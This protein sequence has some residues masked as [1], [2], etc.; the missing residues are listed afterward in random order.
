MLRTFL[1]DIF[2]TDYV[3]FQN[4]TF[5]NVY[6]HYNLYRKLSDGKTFGYILSENLSIRN[7]AFFLFESFGFYSKICQ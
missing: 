4:I 7:L 3:H 5:K 6:L 2:N 1:F